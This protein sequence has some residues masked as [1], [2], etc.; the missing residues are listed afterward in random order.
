M[1]R[2]SA[3]VPAVL[4][5]GLTPGD[6]FGLSAVVG[7]ASLF[8]GVSAG[9]TAGLVEGLVILLPLVNDL[10]LGLDRCRCGLIRASDFLVGSALPL[11][12][13]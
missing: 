11:T 4:L 3:S 10:A 1:T 5:T 2:L 8:G 13:L 12:M 9:L 6:A 7:M